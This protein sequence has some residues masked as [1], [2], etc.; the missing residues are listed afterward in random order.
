MRAN[1]GNEEREGAL[2][3]PLLDERYAP[4]QAHVEDVADRADGPVL[5][6][7]GQR[8]GAVMLDGV[9]AA[10]LFWAAGFLS[11]WDLWLTAI[12]WRSYLLTGLFGYLLFVLVNGYTLL[13]DGQTLGKKVVGIRITRADGSRASLAR[14]LGARYGVG[15]L[16]VM[17]PMLAQAWGLVDSL[18]IFRQSRRCLHDVIADTI[19]LKA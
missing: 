13:R 4:P 16:T 10:G 8:L 1:R 2:T 18:M 17:I 12:G 15:Y 5:A 14:L 7:R 9:I 6:G 3:E 11:G 19:V